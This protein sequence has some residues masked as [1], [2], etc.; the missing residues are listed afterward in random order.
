MARFRQRDEQKEVVRVVKVV[1]RSS[2]PPVVSVS[3]FKVYRGRGFSN[4]Q[5]T[6]WFSSSL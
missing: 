4:P 1:T 5:G 3:S 6:G 2:R